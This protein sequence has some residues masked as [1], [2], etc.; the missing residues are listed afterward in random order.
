MFARP[1]VPPP[2]PVAPVVEVTPPAPSLPTAAS[3]GPLVEGLSGPPPSAETTASGKRLWWRRGNNEKELE[4]LPNGDQVVF[5]P[6]TAT[7]TPIVRPVAAPEPVSSAPMPIPSG[8]EAY[9]AQPTAPVSN[10]LPAQAGSGPAVAVAPTTSVPNMLDVN[11]LFKTAPVAA[12]KPPAG[13]AATV[14][15]Q[16]TLPTPRMTIIAGESTQQEIGLVNLT[17]LPDNF[18]LSVEDLPGNW[19]KFSQSSVN[20]FPNWS[21]PVIFGISLSDKVRPSVY[22]GR[23]IAVSRTQPGVRNEV[24][25]EIEVLAPLKAE[26]RLQPHR[27]RGYKARYNLIVRNRSMCESNVTLSLSQANEFCEA[28]FKPATLTIP[29]GQSLT[30]PLKVQLRA[31]TPSDQARQPQQF[32][33]EVHNEWLVAGQPVASEPLL[34][35]GDYVHESRWELVV[36][37]PKVFIFGGIILLVLALWFWLIVPAIQGVVLVAVDQYEYKGQI[38]GKNLFVEQRSFSDA[39]QQVN[40][41]AAFAIADVHF[42]EQ[43]QETEFGIR[44]PFVNIALTMR[45]QLKLNEN[46]D[47]YFKATD[48]PDPQTFPWLFAPPNQVVEHL[49][50]NLRKWIR[51]E[52]PNNRISRVEIEGT[53]LF[54]RLVACKPEEKGCNA[55]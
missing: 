21:E 6:L 1:S 42:R 33:V 46:G 22:S 36:Q 19:Y 54:V 55:G 35:E 39:V 5:T 12:R 50:K 52:A 49:N 41:L 25:F 11:D 32:E 47:L 44:Q 28:Q 23:I 26:A 48:P 29:P 40:P 45:G 2:P 16:I 15:V 20:L 43:G 9:F 17:A 3:S 31:K 51:Q 13:G 38:I 10:P 4:P 7:P 24:P 27:A 53:T 14:K 37:H 8:L 18:D 30:V 34:V